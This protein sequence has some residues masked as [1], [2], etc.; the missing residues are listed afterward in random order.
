MNACLVHFS[1]MP[2]SDQ[3]DGLSLIVYS[4]SFNVMSAIISLPLKRVN[5]YCIYIQYI[6]RDLKV[7]N[8]LCNALH[9]SF[10]LISYLHLQDFMISRFYDNYTS[11]SGVGGLDST[12]YTMS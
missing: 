5:P 11:R 3:G 2:F 4:M 7:I 8:V 1:Y 10:K 9:V 12:I 6:S